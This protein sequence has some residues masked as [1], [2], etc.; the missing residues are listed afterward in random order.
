VTVNSRGVD[1]AL[2]SA[3]YS[4]EKSWVSNAHSI[5]TAAATAAASTT[6]T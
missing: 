3:T 4:I 2:F 5:T 6:N 1:R